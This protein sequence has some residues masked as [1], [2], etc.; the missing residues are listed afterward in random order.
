MERVA[1][2]LREP[3]AHVAGD[4]ASAVAVL[5]SLTRAYDVASMPI[6]VYDRYGKIHV[7]ATQRIEANTLVLLPCSPL[8]C[9]VHD[10]N[11]NSSPNAVT[12]RVRLRSPNYYPVELPPS[13]DAMEP[14]TQPGVKPKTKKNNGR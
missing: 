12:V 5:H 14:S 9:K 6:E 8:H 3:N 13:L 10:A 7:R 1:I 4:K 11:A 2:C